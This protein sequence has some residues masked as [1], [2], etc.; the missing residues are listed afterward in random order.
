M[1]NLFHRAQEDTATVRE[2]LAAVEQDIAAQEAELDRL[3]LQA[4]LSGDE[5]ASQA[6]ARLDE[7]RHRREMLD[8]AFSA[9]EKAERE[10]KAVASASA[11]LAQKR[12]LSQHLGRFQRDAAEL[13]AALLAMRDV[14]RR[15]TATGAT[16]KALLPASLLDQRFPFHEFLAPG[17]LRDLA[18]VEAFRLSR[19]DVPAPGAVERPLRLGAYEDRRTGAIKPLSDTLAALVASLRSEFDKHGPSKLESPLPAPAMPVLSDPAPVVGA[20]P[21]SSDAGEPRTLGS[22]GE[23]ADLRGQDLGVAKPASEEV[24]DVR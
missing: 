9:S 23:I 7:L 14:F 22:R 16:I 21:R 18:D 13:N 10:A 1:F 8:R 17:F 15:F 19:G 24:A 6:A 2:K 11:F 5:S 12:A 20:G 3:A 4:V